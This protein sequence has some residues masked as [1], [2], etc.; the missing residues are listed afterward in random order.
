MSLEQEFSYYSSKIQ[1]NQ[2][3]VST[4]IPNNPLI[5]LGGDKCTYLNVKLV[6]SKELLEEINTVSETLE[7]APE[8]TLANYLQYANDLK[9]V[10]IKPEIEME[11]DLDYD[12]T[13]YLDVDYDDEKEDYV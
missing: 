5:Y 10:P 1:K 2:P 4:S 12:A 9:L 13:Y 3:S 6:L 11:E 7:I 8:M